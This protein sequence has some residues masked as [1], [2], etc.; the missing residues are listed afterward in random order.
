MP[1]AM[2]SQ[3][4]LLV[5]KNKTE[6]ARRVCENIMTQYREGPVASEAARQLRLLG[7][8][9]APEP[10]A[11]IPNQAAPIPQG[12]PVASAVPSAPKPASPPLKKP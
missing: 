5:E 7:P 4:H 12:A 8:G 10:A 9:K 3:V 1:L 6:E 2:I 11:Q